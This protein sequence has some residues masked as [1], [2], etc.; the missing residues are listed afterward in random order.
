MLVIR[1]SKCNNK[2]KLQSANLDF[3]QYLLQEKR[4]HFSLTYFYY[5]LKGYDYATQQNT[6]IYSPSS[7]PKYVYV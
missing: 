1:N 2:N 3:Q 4:I 5:Y 7:P 6:K